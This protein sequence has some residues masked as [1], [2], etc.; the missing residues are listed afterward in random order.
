M[1]KLITTI[2][3]LSAGLV[4]AQTVN[5]WVNSNG[6]PWKNSVGQC[7]RNG[8]WTPATAHQD[9]DGALKPQPRVQATFTA[10]K[11]EA[12]PAPAPRVEAPKS[13]VTKVSYSADTFFDFDKSVIKPEGKAKLDL[14]VSKLTTVDLEVIVVVGHTDF[15][16]SDAYNLKL[17][18]RRADA[19]KAYLV[20]KGVENKRVFTDSK[21]EKQPIAS[22]QTPAG[23]AKNRRVEIEVVG[24]QR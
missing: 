14:L 22:N 19:V 13:V 17:G 1:K 10:P 6:Q 21:G 11:E 16:G 7:W 3:A 18:Q 4:S 23:R 2:V 15:I 5:N 9:C 20:S 12:A 8:A 24:I